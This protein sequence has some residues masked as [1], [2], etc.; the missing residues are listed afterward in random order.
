MGSVL[1]KIKSKTVRVQT[2]ENLPCYLKN[3]EVSFIIQILSLSQHQQHLYFKQL[4]PSFP[5]SANTVDEQST[6]VGSPDSS[7][8][9]SAAAFQ[10]G[11]TV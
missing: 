2:L 6:G 3:I 7:V 11:F 1:N 4:K 8:L 5:Q 9:S 10:T